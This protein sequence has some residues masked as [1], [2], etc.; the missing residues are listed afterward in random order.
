MQSLAS[1]LA[2]AG[3][4]AVFTGSAAAQPTFVL[5]G[6]VIDENRQ[7]APGLEVLLHRVTPEGGELVADTIA[8]PD[9]S[10]QL[11][12]QVSDGAVFFAAA[13]YKDDVYIGPMLRAPFNDSA[14]YVLQV[15][16]PE[17][18]LRSLGERVDMAT[19]APCAATGTSRRWMLALIPLCALLAVAVYGLLQ[20]RGPT[21]HRRLLIALARLENERA[22]GRNTDDKKAYQE[23]RRQL[24]DRIQ[25]TSE[26]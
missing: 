22:A 7:P 15:G 25:S 23:R 9:G 21:E 2:L 24:L 1:L 11:S 12:G 19:N 14:E 6:R 26:S 3:G 20:V 16:N 8:G 10:F 13:R 5:R 17:M 4:L 18:S